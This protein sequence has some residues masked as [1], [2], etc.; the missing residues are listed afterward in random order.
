M[1]LDE[2][3]DD[4][5]ERLAVAYDEV[6]RETGVMLYPG[7][8]PAL[9]SLGQRFRLGLF[10]NG[11][12]EMQWPKLRALAIEPCF[13]AIVV[14]GDHGLYK[15]DPS[16]FQLLATE[17]ECP[18]ERILFV[19]DNYETDVRGAHDA[20]MHTA[21]IRHPDAEAGVPVCHDLEIASIGEL[22]GGIQ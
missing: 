18:A 12:T 2:P 3:D 14:A 1:L 16:A 5:C 8:E 6:R 15:P 22:E 11:S 21:W 9:R 7:V 19:G 10:T 4:L 20:G 13:D 17:L